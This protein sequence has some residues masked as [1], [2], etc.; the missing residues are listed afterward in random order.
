VALLSAGWIS[1]IHWPTL[2]VH[3]T[4]REVFAAYRGEN[5]APDEPVVAWL[6]NWRGETFYGKDRVR[7][8]TEPARLREIA[9]RPG[10]VWVVTEVERLQSLEGALGGARRMRVAGPPSGRYRLVE[11]VEPPPAGEGVPP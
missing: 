8:V 9:S 5:P 2:A 3:W 4:Q 1:W 6:M 7:E 11:L 10:R